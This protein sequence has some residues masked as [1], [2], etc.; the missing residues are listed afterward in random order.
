MSANASNM[1]KWTSLVL[2]VVQTTVQV[3]TMRYSRI[4]PIEKDAPRYLSSTA[5][6]CAEALK[7]FTCLILVWRQ[8]DWSIQRAIGQVH[9]QIIMNPMDT[10]KICV[11]GVLYTIQ[12]NLLFVALSNLDAGTYQ[13]TYQLKILTTAIFCVIMLNKKLVVSQ[14]FSL[15]IL[16]AGVALVQLAEAGD[17]GKGATESGMQSQV[18]GLV[19]VLSACVSSGFAGVYLEKMLKHSAPS[20]WMRNI[21]LGLYGIGSGLVAV[22][23]QDFAAVSEHGFFGG[24]SSLVWGVVALQALGGLVI[25]AVIKYADNIL[26]GF[27]NAT[28]IVLS[29]AVSFALLADTRLTPLFFFGTGF[30]V[31]ATMLYA[32]AP[33]SLIPKSSHRDRDLL[34]VSR[35]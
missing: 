23:V 29:A 28:S 34:A 19:A 3:L 8:C 35:V 21:Q 20:I 24:Y 11:P 7:V 31:A 26:K 32:I 5:V 9:D 18:V 27:A 15:V 1:M 6:V 22:F 17:T 2:L 33:Q 13:V 30:V 14:W 10:V 12:N 16:T 4:A 25:A